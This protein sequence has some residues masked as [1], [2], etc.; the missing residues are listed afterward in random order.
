MIG[1]LRNNIGGPFFRA[2]GKNPV[3]FGLYTQAHQ[4]VGAVY[5]IVLVMEGVV[6][7]PDAASTSGGSKRVTK[8]LGFW[9]IC[10]KSLYRTDSCQDSM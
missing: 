1:Q 3:T 2:A 7:A 5:D 6:I 8:S 9:A 10:N 4:I